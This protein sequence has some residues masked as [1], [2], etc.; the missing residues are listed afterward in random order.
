MKPRRPAQRK[1]VAAL[2]QI[3]EGSLHALRRALQFTTDP[4]D[5]AAIEQEITAVSAD[6]AT[7]RAWLA[8]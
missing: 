5:R 4:T 3:G 8:D 7:L 2:L 1:H 6:V